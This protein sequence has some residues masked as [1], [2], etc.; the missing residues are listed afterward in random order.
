VTDDGSV[1]FWVG[2]R[3]EPWAPLPEPAAVDSGLEVVSGFSICERWMS[4]PPLKNAPSSIT[5]PAVLTSPT[6]CSTVSTSPS[7]RAPVYLCEG[8]EQGV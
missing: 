8:S 3:F 4:M 7:P 5:T 6:T 2:S 1:G